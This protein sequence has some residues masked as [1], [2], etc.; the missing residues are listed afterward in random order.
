MLQIKTG[1][2]P[3]IDALVEQRASGVA[4]A[5][6]PLTIVRRQL[7][8]F[9]IL[10]PCATVLGLLY[11][12]TTPS[13]YTAVAKIVIDIRKAEAFQHAQ[14]TLGDTA[15]IDTALIATEVQVLMSPN[16]SLAVIKA[17]NLT[18]DPEFVRPG[19]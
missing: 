7:P 3:S 13:S 12:L 1:S 19:G 5:L 4:E 9:L 2:A 16:I 10:I 15:P 14:Q 8:I 18:E 6:K 11:L 17:L